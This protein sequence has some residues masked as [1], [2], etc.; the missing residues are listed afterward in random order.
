MHCAARTAAQ[1]VD[2]RRRVHQ[3]DLLDRQAPLCERR[4]C[5][6]RRD[7]AVCE[8]ARACSQQG[9]ANLTQ[10]VREFAQIASEDIRDGDSLYTTTLDEVAKNASPAARADLPSAQADRARRAARYRAWL[11]AHMSGFRAGGFAVGRKQYD[12]YLRR[13]LMLPFDSS[14][15]ARHRAA[16]AGARPSA[17]VV[18]RIARR[19]CAG[20]IPAAVVPH[21]D[22]LLSLLRKQPARRSSRSSTRTRSSLSRRT[23][24]RS[25]SSKSQRRLRRRIRAGS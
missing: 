15:V 24:G 13:V 7:R 19:A 14:E 20:G 6:P 12:W 16:G 25:I 3:W 22:G 1:S 10:T 2:L 4:H 18:G 9:R 21:E 5:A 17:G 11:D 23:S 8:P